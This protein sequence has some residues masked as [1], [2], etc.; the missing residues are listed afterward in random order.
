MPIELIR[1]GQRKAV[2]VTIG[3]RPPEDQL[4]GTANPGDDESD[5]N[6]AQANPDQSTRN[7]LGLGF[8]TLTPELDRKLGLPG[9]V[10]GVVINYVDP[11]SDAGAVG[12]QPR[13]VILQI[14]QIPVTSS[15][16]AAAAIEAARKAKKSTVL[17]FVQRGNNPGRYIGVKLKGN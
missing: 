7:T 11:S 4:A 13:D 2:V 9:T 15:Q 10:R 6:A 12:L 16:A 3:E 14:D 17:L 1:E 5:D 8:Q